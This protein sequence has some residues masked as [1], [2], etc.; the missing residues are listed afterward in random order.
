[1]QTLLWNIMFILSF[2][3]L[4]MHLKLWHLVCNSNFEFELLIYMGIFIKNLITL[5][6]SEGWWLMPCILLSSSP[7][8]CH[9]PL[10][11]PPSIKNIYWLNS[12]N[13]FI[14]YISIHN[15]LHFVLYCKIFYLNQFL[16][17]FREI[18][19]L[20]SSRYFYFFHIYTKK[21]LAT[22]SDPSTQH[23]TSWFPSLA[24]K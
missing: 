7:N 22:N 15:E 6:C 18:K 21:C 13:L 20:S 23:Y 8:L 12:W 19:L 5:G 11:P 17:P 1:M 14:Q 16:S 3:L 4:C 2:T 10:L 9:I 24:S